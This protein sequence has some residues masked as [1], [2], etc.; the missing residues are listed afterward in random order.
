MPDATRSQHPTLLDEVH[1]VLRLHHDSMHTE[2]SSVAWLVRFVRF[3]G[4]RSR[5]NLF[6]AEPT[7]DACLTDLPVHGT[8]AP[9][10]QNQAMHALVFLDTRVL[11]HALPGRI[12]AVRADKTITVPVVMTREAVAAV[13]SR[14]DG[15]AHVVATLLYGSGLRSMETV[16][17]R[18]KDIDDQMKPLTVRAGT[19][20]QDRVTTVPATRTPLLQ[21]H[22]AGI[23]TR[24]QQDL[25]QG[26]WRGVP[27]ACPGSETPP[28]RQGMRLAVCLSCPES[29]R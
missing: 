1:Q 14:M 6:P 28:C 26:A 19:G 21:N 9:A 5:Q 2:R 20:D 29:L 23:K 18:V 3:H 4:M 12:D 15:T 11:T 17:L 10:T 8:V 22:L 16:R 25:A 13:L 24:H 7:I 27:P